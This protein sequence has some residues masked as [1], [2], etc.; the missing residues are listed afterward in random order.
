MSPRLV[1][2]LLS[3]GWVTLMLLLLALIIITP[4]AMPFK[5]EHEDA[6]PHGWAQ[7]A[8]TKGPYCHA[9][10]Q[11]LAAGLLRGEFD[12]PRTEEMPWGEQH[13]YN[14]INYAGLVD[15]VCKGEAQGLAAA[16]QKFGKKHQKFVTRRGKELIADG[17]PLRWV[18][19]NA[20]QL[21]S[22]AAEPPGAMEAAELMMSNAAKLGLKVARVWAFR[23]GSDWRPPRYRQQAF[24][25]LQIAPGLY[26]ETMFRA[27]DEVIVAAERAGV[28]V[29]LT[30]TNWHHD[31]GGIETY[32]KWVKGGSDLSDWTV[33]NFYADA[34]T[35]L[36]FK[37]N[38]VAMALRRNSVTG[39]LYR[40]DPTIISWDLINEPRCSA[41]PGATKAEALQA[42]VGEMSGFMKSLD[43]HH[44]VTV[45]SEGYYGE[46]TTELMLANPGL[47]AVCEGM[48]YHQLYSLPGVDYAVAHLYLE[49]KTWDDFAKANCDAKCALSWSRRWMQSHINYTDSV[50]GKPFVLEE[51]GLPKTSPGSK[52]EL[53]KMV[54][55]TLKAALQDGRAS[56]TGSNFWAAAVQSEPDW[57]GYYLYL[58]GSLPAPT[59]LGEGLDEK[60]QA[61]WDGLQDARNAFRRKLQVEKCYET[62]KAQYAY[63]LDGA[64]TQKKKE[65]YNN[66]LEI[67]VEAISHMNTLDA[68]RRLV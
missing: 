33:Y 58:D 27:L 8:G 53:F 50:L 56:V 42:W 41:C 45:S 47:W 20:P 55:D 3:G 21:L 65:Y 37:A 51:F 1:S 38:L 35:R 22:L 28:Y 16:A 24:A 59:P 11:Q 14:P 4:H 57:D 31:Y 46:S 23:D 13:V 19:F 60:E 43:P 5:T 52:D 25:P 2:A 9:L 10:E 18:G 12:K 34:R 30:L 17:A 48:D 61:Y 49:M 64:R 39:R 63:L 7:E 66:T 44:L 62:V 26:N 15:F 29:T 40:D 54:Y 6:M 32:V 36:L 68:A 67:V